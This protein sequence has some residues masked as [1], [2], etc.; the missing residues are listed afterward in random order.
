MSGFRAGF[1][2]RNPLVL[3]VAA[4]R[5]CVP[6]LL[7]LRVAASRS[8]AWSAVPLKYWMRRPATTITYVSWTVGHEQ[9]AP[10]GD[11]GR[12]P[13]RRSTAREAIVSGRVAGRRGRG[14]RRPA[15]SPPGTSPRINQNFAQRL[16]DRRQ[17]ARTPGV[18]AHRRQPRVASRAIPAPERQQVVG[19]ELVLKSVFLQQYVVARRT[20]S[21]RYSYTILP[22]IFSY[23]HELPAEARHRRCSRPGLTARQY[24]QHRYT[25]ERIHTPGAEGEDGRRSGTASATRCSGAISPSTSPCSSS[26]SSAASSAACAPCSWSCRSTS[27]RRQGPLRRGDRPV[28]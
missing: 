19:R 22:G 1:R 4:G 10:A 9:A 23:A 27:D 15:A 26:S 3:L 6:A 13:P 8:G 21:Y 17:R 7:G 12:V 24:R 16:A 25:L 14:A 20:A 11:A 18:G 28:P 2:S 5:C